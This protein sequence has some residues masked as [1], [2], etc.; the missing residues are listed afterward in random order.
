VPEIIKH[1][2]GVIAVRRYR[3]SAAQTPLAGV[4]PAPYVAIYDLD[5][6]ADE[7]LVNFGAAAG[8]LTPSEVLGTGDRAPV[9][10]LYDRI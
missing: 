7:V 9:S 2:H 5:L 10:V 3:V 6:P 8:R 4:D 1:V